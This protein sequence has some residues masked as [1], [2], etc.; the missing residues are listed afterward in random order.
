VTGSRSDHPIALLGSRP[1]LASILPLFLSIG[2]L[3]TPNDYNGTFP[4]SINHQGEIAG[5]Y[6]TR[7][8]S[9]MVSFA[10]AS[11]GGRK[12]LAIF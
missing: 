1:E 9:L 7:A 5:Y 2:V 3:E 10:L 12:Y 6:L 11:E 4:V 8:M